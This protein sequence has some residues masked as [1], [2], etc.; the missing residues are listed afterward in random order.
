[1]P[2]IKVSF[3]PEAAKEVGIAQQWYAERSPLTA[4]AFPA[5]LDLGVE[6]IREAPQR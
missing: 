5:E 1:M 2:P 6:R 3:H 4:R